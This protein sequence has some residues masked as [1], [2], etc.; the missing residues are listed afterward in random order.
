MQALGGV[1]RR[2]AA[3][4]VVH[5]SALVDDDQRPLEL[6]HALRVD[7]EVGLQ[8]EV[9]LHPGRNVDKRPTRPD[10]RVQR[11]EFIVVRRDDFAEVLAEQFG[12]LLHRRVRIGEDDALLGEFLLERSVDYLAL[13]LGFHARDQTLLLRL[14]NAELVVGVLNFG[15]DIFPGGRLLLGWLE[16]IVD[17]IEVD[18]DL[19]APVG[20]W[21]RLE[22]LERPETEL[23]HPLGLALH[24]RDLLDD[25][26][27]Q[28]LA[29]FEHAG[30]LGDEVVLVDI[31]DDIGFASDGRVSVAITTS[32]Y[33]SATEWWRR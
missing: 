5:R 10:G 1:H 20:H 18:A 7:A 27:V 23:P 26:A 32:C 8:R 29:S 16:V 31:A 17:I 14:E 15:R 33:C 12:V 2:R 11:G 6:P 13:E 4:D 19:A 21:F 28:T 25:F 3:L 30:R 9:D 22:D 24:L